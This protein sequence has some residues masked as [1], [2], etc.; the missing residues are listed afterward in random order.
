MKQKIFVLML[1]ALLLLSACTPADPEAVFGTTTPPETTKPQV[2][3]T[4]AGAEPGYA[5][6]NMH[7]N[8]PSGDYAYDGT[9]VVFQNRDDGLLT[10]D[11]ETGEIQPFCQDAT[12]THSSSRCSSSMM[13]GNLE[14]YDGTLYASGI[15]NDVCAYGDGTFSRVLEETGVYH[16]FHANGD[17]YAATQDSTLLRFPGGD[18][19]PEVV[20]EEYAGFWETIFGNFLYY[21]DSNNLMRLDL[22]QEGAQPEILRSNVLHLTD[23]AH[24][25]YTP[26]DTWELYRCDMEGNNQ[27]LIFEGPTLASR[28]GFD[29]AYFYYL[30]HTDFTDNPHPS[31]EKQIDLWRF[32]KADPSAQEYLC[33]LP[34][35]DGAVYTLPGY[36]RIFIA[37]YDRPDENSQPTQYLYTVKTDGTDLREHPLP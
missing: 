30:L 28:A 8:I 31:G 5:Y 14:W 27:E 7:K 10:F 19:E 20:L 6:S 21:H 11:L 36:E 25:Y 12:C 18:G 15:S 2:S 16:F 26:M 1:A 22:S 13:V 34:V 35:S 4:L 32:P 29:D 17:L 33:T 23:G 3:G 9:R 24:I 37:C